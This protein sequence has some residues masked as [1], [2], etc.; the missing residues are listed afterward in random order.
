MKVPFN[1]LS[2]I[3]DPL[4]NNILDKFSKVIDR[5]DFILN[6]DV[7]IFEKTFQNIRI[8]NTSFLVPTAQMLLS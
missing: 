7:E 2:R 3:H 4:K 8:K 1:D 5:N 6:N